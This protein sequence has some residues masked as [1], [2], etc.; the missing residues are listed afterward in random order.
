MKVPTSLADLPI[1]ESAWRAF[2]RAASDYR[3]AWTTASETLTREQRARCRRLAGDIPPGGDQLLIARSELHRAAELLALAEG[4]LSSPRDDNPMEACPA[5]K[6]HGS[7]DV[8][9]GG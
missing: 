9:E 7:R 1:Q 5:R 3:D 2:R 8:S 4:D 6:P